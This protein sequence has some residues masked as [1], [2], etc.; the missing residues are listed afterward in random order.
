MF[1][2]YLILFLYNNPPKKNAEMSYSCI[3]ASSSTGK[4]IEIGAVWKAEPCSAAIQCD[5][6]AICLYSKNKQK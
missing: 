4:K 3:L 1:F 5:I 2:K 6:V